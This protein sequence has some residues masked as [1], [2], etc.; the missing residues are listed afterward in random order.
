V[1]QVSRNAL[2]G[3][4]LPLANPS[5]E[6]MYRVTVELPA[7]A[8]LTQGTAHKLQAGMLVDA[9]IALE[10]RRLYEWMFGQVFSLSGRAAQ[11]EDAMS[12]AGL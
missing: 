1:T 12:R 9:N 3:S 4:E 10:R 11:A 8:I 6:P 2:V 7:Q 5:Q